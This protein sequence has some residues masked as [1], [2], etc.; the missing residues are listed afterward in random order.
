MRKIDFAGF[1]LFDG[2]MGTRLLE[3]GF[4]FRPKMEELNLTHPHII[5]QIHQEY[6]DAG[7]DFITTATFG[8]NGY[9]YQDSLYSVSEI[10]M[11]AIHN[12]KRAAPSKFI[13]LDIGPIGQLLEPYGDMTEQACYG[14]FEEIIE[15]GKDHVDAILFETFMDLEEISIGI[16][17]AKDITSLPVLATM[18]FNRDGRTMMGVS[19]ETMIETFESMGVDVL[20]VNC[21][22]GPQDLIPVVEQ[23]CKQSK[24]PII[25]Q[26]NAGLPHTQEDGSLHY[27]I[28]AKEFTDVARR[29]L[30]LGVSIIGGCCG[31]NSKTI[32]K[33]SSLKQ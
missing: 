6:A 20:G 9:K 14:Y 4:P 21:S 7:A 3:L 29:Y 1:Q 18:T 33:I 23:L 11:A 32:R 27:D 16:R 2:A 30:S 12:A 13:V 19:V 17:C 26:P 8:V 24:T 22:W 10:V 28:D 15:A 5:Q 25:V 31:T